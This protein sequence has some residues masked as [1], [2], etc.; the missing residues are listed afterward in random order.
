MALDA[1]LKRY[2]TADNFAT[3][4]TLGR[5]GAPSTHVMWIG[6]DDEH[7]LINTEVH[8]Q[9]FK[10]MSRD[11]RVVVTVIDRESPYHYIEAR[12]RVVDTVKGDEARQ[13]IDELSNR[14]TGADYGTPIKS[15]RVIVKIA[16]DRVVKK[17]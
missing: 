16:V 7:L 6:A 13:H 11:P 10:N 8:R 5:D 2:S 4:T 17:I 3:L 14:Y 1:D 9:K 12:G 15:E